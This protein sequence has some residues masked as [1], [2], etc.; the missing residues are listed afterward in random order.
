MYSI[1]FESEF[2]GLGR[3]YHWR[4]SVT[5]H[6]KTISYIFIG[7]FLVIVILF[8]IG[9]LWE[10]RAYWEMIISVRQLSLIGY[11]WGFWNFLI[12]ME[13]PALSRFFWC[14]TVYSLFLC[15]CY[16]LLTISAR[17]ST[18]SHHETTY[19]NFCQLSNTIFGLLNHKILRSPPLLPHLRP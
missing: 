2:T 16:C 7:L 5:K 14:L 4:V 19:S 8:L 15:S 10:F 17:C 9:K 11:K 18:E 12:V 13:L 1:S 3:D 6:D